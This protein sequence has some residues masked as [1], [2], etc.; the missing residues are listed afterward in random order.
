MRR[1]LALAFDVA[2]KVEDD[3]DGAQIGRGR[4]GGGALPSCL[5]ICASVNRMPS[6]ASREQSIKFW[7]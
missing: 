2:Q 4:A 6:C 3:P 1:R 7:K 5:A